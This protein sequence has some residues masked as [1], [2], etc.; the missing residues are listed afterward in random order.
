MFKT[1]LPLGLL[2]VF[3]LYGYSQNN[4]TVTAKQTKTTQTVASSG[5]VVNIT[6]P[7]CVIINGTVLKA[8]KMMVVADKVIVVA[9]EILSVLL[10][11]KATPIAMAART[12]KVVGIKTVPLP[13][14]LPLKNNNGALKVRLNFINNLV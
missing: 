2:F 1:M 8:M 6:Q 12:I 13:R 7:V 9:L 11:A 14:P 10:P 4:T 5:K 3:A